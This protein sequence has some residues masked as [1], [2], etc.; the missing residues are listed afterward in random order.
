MNTR[1]SNINSQTHPLIHGTNAQALWLSAKKAPIKT[2]LMPLRAVYSIPKSVSAW[3]WKH[4]RSVDGFDEIASALGIATA[5]LAVFAAGTPLV[6]PGALGA[7]EEYAETVTQTR[8]FIENVRAENQALDACY[9][10][11][12]RMLALYEPDKSRSLNLLR[13]QVEDTPTTERNTQTYRR[14]KQRYIRVLDREM[15]SLEHRSQIADVSSSCRKLLCN[16]KT[17]EIYR[18]EAVKALKENLHQ[19]RTHWTGAVAMAGMGTSMVLGITKT[20]WEVIDKASLPVQMGTALSGMFMGSQILMALYGGVRIHDGLKADSDLKQHAK[21]IDS[22]S[23]SFSLKHLTVEENNTQATYAFKLLSQDN[24]R[25]QVYN[26]LGGTWYGGVTA[27]GQSCMATGTGLIL[28]TGGLGALASAPLFAIGVPLTLL[29]AAMRST[30]E[31]CFKRYTGN[32]EQE[33]TYAT[34]DLPERDLP[35]SP[36]ASW[37]LS[38][39]AVF[40]FQQKPKS[41]INTNEASPVII[42]DTVSMPKVNDAKSHVKFRDQAVETITKGALGLVEHKLF[43]HVRHVIGQRDWADMSTEDRYQAII[44]RSEQSSVFNLRGNR[45][46]LL[47]K[48]RDDVST[49]A[50]QLFQEESSDGLLTAKIRQVVHHDDQATA[51]EELLRVMVEPSGEQGI[52]QRAFEKMREKSAE[53][54]QEYEVKFFKTLEQKGK[55]QFFGGVLGALSSSMLPNRFGGINL[56][57]LQKDPEQSKKAYQYLQ[58]YVSSRQK[59]YPNIHV[60]VSQS[61]LKS[62]LG[63]G[64]RESKRLLQEGFGQMLLAQRLYG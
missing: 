5:E 10:D 57:K 42:R 46:T 30:V 27:I 63:A 41:W 58:Q 54:N 51:Y 1:V 55:R 56:K 64:K 24:K 28:G 60:K 50:R 49:L 47:K 40:G 25:R 62:L 9:T 15:R 11:M 22:Y 19:V 38:L 32:K 33:A 13:F 20:A 34:Y 48:N 39:R 18:E 61:C 12:H 7:C 36:K 14:N 53:G 26:R 21:A 6:I 23:D 35:E 31:A 4:L 29:G 17:H 16:T 44:K 37:Q 59:E 8:E 45:T 2:A 52:H 43:S 3:S